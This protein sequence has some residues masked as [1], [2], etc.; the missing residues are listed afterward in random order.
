MLFVAMCFVGCD[1]LLVACYCYMLL[2]VCGCL[3]VVC[4]VFFLAFLTWFDCVHGVE[5]CVVFVV[6]FMKGVSILRN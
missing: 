2:V 1:V 3:C 4:G 6:H 5:N